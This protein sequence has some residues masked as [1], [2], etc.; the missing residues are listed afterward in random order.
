MTQEQ[1][2]YYE[3][4]TNVDELQIYEKPNA[5]D[6]IVTAKD[7]EILGNALHG[8]SVEEYDR[9]CSG[10]TVIDASSSVLS[11]QPSIKPSS[12]VASSAITSS[13]AIE[14]PLPETPNATHSQSHIIS[15][16]PLATSSESALPA[17]TNS[18]STSI[19]DV[20]D[21]E[22]PSAKKQ[23]ANH[24]KSHILSSPP[25]A[26]TLESN[27]EPATGFMQMAKQYTS[28]SMK[29]STARTNTVD[30]TEFQIKKHSFLKPQHH[31]IFL[32]EGDTKKLCYRKIQPH[33]YN[34]GFQNTLYRIPLGKALER[35]TAVAETKRQAYQNQ[36]VIAWGEAIG[37]SKAKDNSTEFKNM[38]VTPLLFVYEMEYK[39]R[40]LRWA[41]P[42]LLTH[43]MICEVIDKP[44]Q[45]IAS[46]DSHGMGYFTN[47]G[48]LKL[49][50][51]TMA[52]VGGDSIDE[53]EALL[54][55]SCC[56][57]VDLLREVV[58]KAVGIRDGG[59]A[60]SI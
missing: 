56:T 58:E 11:P 13:P 29:S 7:T 38:T 45:V 15:S 53:L 40:R 43:N 54:V 16:I 12:T 23:D 19:Q 33:S 37:N 57:L 60:G 25:A 39:T 21:S 1:K 2:R 52:D 46:F 6:D 26:T 48:K 14:P 36:M 17:D 5:L 50:N 51:A 59:V 42:S 24:D 3:E 32:G 44:R 49:H 41:R 18:V 9:Q 20:P 10:L 47:I 30:S 55:I 8:L 4:P 34:W 31:E 22:V 35:G 27:E 28:I